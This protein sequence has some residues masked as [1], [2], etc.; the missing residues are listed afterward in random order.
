MN[1]EE[2]WQECLAQKKAKLSGKITIAQMPYSVR[3]FYLKRLNL[4]LGRL[5]N[6]KRK[7]ILFLKKF[8]NREDI[9]RYQDLSYPEI[10][11]FIHMVYMDKAANEINPLVM[12]WLNGFTDFINR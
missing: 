2:L 1:F 4:I 10:A 8:F 6:M 12:E 9:F 5:S 7:N 11:A 3:R